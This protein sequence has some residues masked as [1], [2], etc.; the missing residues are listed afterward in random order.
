MS[1]VDPDLVAL[2]GA[3]GFVGRHVAAALRARGLRVRA[4]ARRAD[5]RLEALGVEIVR[6]ALD[7]PEALRALVAGAGAVVHGAG[8]VAAPSARE[9][10][11]ANAEGTAR[12]VETA[13]QRA[14]GA[15]FVLI[16]SLAAREPNLSPYARSKREAERALEARSDRLHPILVRPPAV[17]GP[18]DRATLPIVAQLAR[19]WLLAP[20]APAN[21]FS[22]IYVE[23]LADLVGELV[24]GAAPSALLEPDDGRPGGYG[25][26]ELADA[27]AARLGKRVRLVELPRPVM[28]AAALLTELGARPLGRTP[29]LSRGKVAELFHPDWVAGASVPPG[30][31]PRVQFDEGFARTLAWYRAEGWL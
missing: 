24:T 31:R 5:A 4:L 26:R 2:T 3:T 21:R 29:R 17:Y 7:Q 8:L 30:W 9:F 20:K 15:R 27:A 28:V 23:D 16:S 12:L 1:R 13:A 6:G 11:R 10:H 25:W 14:E 18:G 19:G 22:L